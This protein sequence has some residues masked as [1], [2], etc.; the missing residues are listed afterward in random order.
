MNR[1]F[2]V[3]INPERPQYSLIRGEA[4]TAEGL[5]FDSIW[6]SDHIFGLVGS[7]ANPFF[8]CWTTMSAL[9]A[10]TQR[11][12]LGQLVMCNPFRH[13]P[14]VAKMGATLDSISDGRL[15]LG[16][17]TGWAEDEFRAYGYPRR[18]RSSGGCGP[19]KG[20]ASRDATMRSMVL[21]VPQSLSR[22]PTLLS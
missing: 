2:G 13:P 5:G 16:L 9:A 10:E 3:F 6:L 21:F 20:L 1:D 7:P 4:L 12:R 19:R 11:I 17:G 22:N 15:I 8:E 18:C 14:L